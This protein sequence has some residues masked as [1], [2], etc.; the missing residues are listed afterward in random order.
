MKSEGFKIRRFENG[1]ER[2]IARP[3][4]NNETPDDIFRRPLSLLGLVRRAV[5][6]N[7][8]RSMIARASTSGV[9]AFAKAVIASVTAAAAARIDRIAGSAFMFVSSFV[10]GF[11]ALFE[12]QLCLDFL[13]KSK[14]ISPET[15]WRSFF[16]LPHATN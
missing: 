6:S 10:C 8:R 11:F 9:H 5:W 14:R 13:A 4:E 16:M 1:V 3:N 2:A 15:L 12:M 7:R